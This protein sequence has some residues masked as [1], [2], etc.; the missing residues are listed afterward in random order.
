MEKAEFATVIMD[1][2]GRACDVIFEDGT[3]ISATAHGSYK[4]RG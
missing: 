1:V 2:E 3:S 4:V